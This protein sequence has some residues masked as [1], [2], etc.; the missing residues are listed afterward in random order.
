MGKG[1]ILKGGYLK[2]EGYKSKGNNTK[3]CLKRGLLFELK[4]SRNKASRKMP[5]FELF[6][7]AE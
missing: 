3:N 7:T 4:I 2:V 1:S 5:D 6:L